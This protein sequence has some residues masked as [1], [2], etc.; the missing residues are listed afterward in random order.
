[1]HDPQ[2]GPRPDDH[3]SEHSREDERARFSRDLETVRREQREERHVCDGEAAH[4]VEVE[5]EPREETERPKIASARSVWRVLLQNAAR[6]SSVITAL[7]AVRG[8][9]AERSHRATRSSDGRIGL[10][11]ESVSRM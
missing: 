10:R 11:N 3:Q 1:M 9:A 8:T 6:T 2:R 7:I 5:E 4:A